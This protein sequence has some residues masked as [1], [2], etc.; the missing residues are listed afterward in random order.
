M[1]CRALKTAGVDLD[2]APT[3]E[4]WPVNSSTMMISWVCRPGEGSGRSWGSKLRTAPSEVAGALVEG[5]WEELR[6]LPA[7]QW[8]QGPRSWRL[9]VTSE[10]VKVLKGSLPVERLTQRLRSE[11]WQSS[12]WRSS[13]ASARERCSELIWGT[14]CMRGRRVG[15]SAVVWGTRECAAIA[16]G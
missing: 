8:G 6:C 9:R 2:E 14:A 13:A 7:V 16:T 4:R 11:G 12:M 15:C 10:Q 1:W 5:G 3:T